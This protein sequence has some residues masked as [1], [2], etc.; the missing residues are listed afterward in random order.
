MKLL[1]AASIA[2]L[3]ALGAGAAQA[4]AVGSAAVGPLTYSVTR[5]LATRGM[6]DRHPVCA[7]P[8]QA[9]LIVFYSVSNGGAAPQPTGGVARFALAS[10][11]AP[12][13]TPD[14][15]ALGDLSDEALPERESP[16]PTLAPGQ[17]MDQVDVFVLKLPDLPKPGLKLLAGDKPID[18]S[19]PPLSPY[20]PLMCDEAG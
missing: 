16:G 8:G 11:A 14:R 13:M 7:G 10:A 15:G 9:F 17:A 5:V 12:K 19:P 6:G 1:T 20:A 2:L 18:L 4:Q 3:A